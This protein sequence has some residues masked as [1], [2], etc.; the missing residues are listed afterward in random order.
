MPGFLKSIVGSFTDPVFLTVIVASVN[1][2]PLGARTFEIIFVPFFRIGSVTDRFLLLFTVR[3]AFFA[4]AENVV[5][6]TLEVVVV[7]KLLAL[8]VNPLADDF[9]EG[10]DPLDGETTGRGDGER[11]GRSG[12]LSA[13]IKVEG[14]GDAVGAGLSVLGGDGM[15]AGGAAPPPPPNPPPPDEPPPDEP[16]PDE[17]PPD[18][19]PPEVG[20]DVISIGEVGCA[21]ADGE[22]EASGDTFSEERIVTSSDA[23]DVEPAVLTAVTAFT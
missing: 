18:E 2:A 20:A 4:G 22:A 12:V 15:T 5:R 17:P 13:G 16:P 10:E 7:K 3:E 8:G 14:E 23:T 19:P 11:D 9:G 1:T 21:E 6:L